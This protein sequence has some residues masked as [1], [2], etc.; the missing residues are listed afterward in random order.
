MWRSVRLTHRTPHWVRL[1]QPTPH[2]GAEPG[3]DAVKDSFTAFKL[4]QL[5]WPGIAIATAFSPA[6]DRHGVP[7]RA[8]ATKACS[9]VVRRAASS[10]W[11]TTASHADAQSASAV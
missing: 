11:F 5:A 3:A 4:R 10:V 8:A 1:T 9:A 2:W 7:R 6:S